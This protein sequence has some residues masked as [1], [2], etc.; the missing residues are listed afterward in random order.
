MNLFARNCF[1]LLLMMLTV[2][3]SGADTIYLEDTVISGN[4]ELPKVLYILPWQQMKEAPLPERAFPFAEQNYL[5]PIYP[6]SH[7]REIRYRQQ[8]KADQSSHL[9][10]ND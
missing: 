9:Q 1:G 10:E 6:S 8:L 4:Q 2:T 5:T 7:K 3:A